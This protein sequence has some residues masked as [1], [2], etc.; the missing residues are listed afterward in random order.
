MYIRY[1]FV[2]LAIGKL[3]QAHFDQLFWVLGMGAKNGSDKWKCLCYFTI[4]V[5]Y[6][7]KRFG[8]IY[9]FRA[10]VVF[11]LR[12]VQGF[13]RGNERIVSG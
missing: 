12:M 1:P 10:A 11:N 8:G 13:H 4:L 6:P 7:G 5:Q 9:V 2:F 3:Y